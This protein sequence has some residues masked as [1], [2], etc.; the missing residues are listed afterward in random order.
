MTK[1]GYMTYGGLPQVVQFSVERQK[2]EYQKYFSK[3]SGMFV[4]RNNIKMLM[5]LAYFCIGAPTNQLKYQI[6]SKSERGI[7]YSNKFYH[8]APE[9]GSWI[10]EACGANL[11]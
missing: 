9:T 8:I 11:K 1:L 5:K 6:L 2:A 7:N 3:L 10:K 4:E